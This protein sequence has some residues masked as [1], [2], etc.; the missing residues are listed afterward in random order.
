M[1]ELLNRTKIIFFLMVCLCFALGM[2]TACAASDNGT[3]IIDN[4]NELEIE[5]QND[6]ETVAS[7]NIED[8][9]VDKVDDAVDD[10][11][12][13]E[14]VIGSNGT[15][16]Y[17]QTVIDSNE[18]V[19]ILQEKGSKRDLINGLNEAV[20]KLQPGDTIDLDKDYF[21]MNSYIV[22]GEPLIID[23][24]N[25]TINGN[26]HIIDGSSLHTFIKI[27]G[28]NVKIN[29]VTF[30]NSASVTR[31]TYYHNWTIDY[32]NPSPRPDPEKFN[33]NGPK[34]VSIEKPINWIG[35]NGTISNCTFYT[36]ER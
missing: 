15:V 4:G 32:N 35:E 13:N 30:I 17:D 28:K 33:P 3:D 31:A 11:D 12:A 7:E 21:V 22:R 16:E 27:T 23:V 10:V 24:D 8:F 20:S 14:S 26:G 1:N 19:K 18:Y 6:I 2:S 29:N 5:Q 25:I 9:D 34:I 36:L